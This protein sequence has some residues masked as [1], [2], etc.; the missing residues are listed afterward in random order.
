MCLIAAYDAGAEPD[1][2]ALRAAAAVNTD[3]YGFAIWKE[4]GEFI[5]FYSR[6]F[7]ELLEFFLTARRV[8][9]GP[10]LVHMRWRTAG[11]DHE[12][13]LQPM[14]VMLQDGEAMVAHN[15]TFNHITADHRSDTRIFVE[16]QLASRLHPP[17]TVGRLFPRKRE[18]D[19]TPLWSVGTRTFDKWLVEEGQKLAVITHDG[20][21]LIL[22]N[23]ERDHAYRGVGYSCSDY[24][25]PVEI[26]GRVDVP[27]R[28]H[29]LYRDLGDRQA[30]GDSDAAV[31]RAILLG[32]C[33]ALR[34][35]VSELKR[36]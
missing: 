33:P 23:W 1:V 24:I 15:G 3:G 26:H 16:Q 32:I 31:Q 11:A 30:E 18:D 17:Y 20:R 29:M 21:L 6:D 5:T 10:A 27:A 8:H 36:L 13:N 14:R 35:G 25:P 34:S 28:M 12:M 2:E 7:E 22:G 4:P 19:S 9:K